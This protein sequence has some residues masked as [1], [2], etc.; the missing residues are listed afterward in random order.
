MSVGA[1]LTATLKLYSGLTGR[2]KGTPRASRPPTLTLSAFHCASVTRRIG[3]VAG[4]I[5]TTAGEATVARVASARS[6]SIVGVNG[7]WGN[8]CGVGS[9]EQA[10]L[11]RRRFEENQ[12][13][14]WVAEMRTSRV[15]ALFESYDVEMRASS[16]R[17]SWLWISRENRFR[18]ASKSSAERC[19]AR[20]QRER[21]VHERERRE[22]AGSRTKEEMEFVCFVL[23]KSRENGARHYRVPAQGGGGQHVRCCAAELPLAGS[24]GARSI[25]RLARTAESAG[26][27]QGRGPRARGEECVVAPASVPP[28]I[29]LISNL[30]Q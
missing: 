27:R 16:C 8:E 4:R 7:A 25:P 1:S 24:L 18:D 6:S 28:R 29:R 21:V 30:F 11:E 2:A 26:P 20:V 10:K 19:A 3:G 9:R 15:G 5:R 12:W 13:R 23:P 22:S 14:L 17:C